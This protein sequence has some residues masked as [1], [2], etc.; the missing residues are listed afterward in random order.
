M[1]PA[2]PYR[3]NKALEKKGLAVQ[4]FRDPSGYYY[5][6]NEGPEDI[7]SIYSNNLSH[8]SIPEVIEYV[9]GHIKVY[10]TTVPVLSTLAVPKAKAIKQKKI[11]R[12]FD[13]GKSWT[14]MGSLGTA[15]VKGTL[16]WGA[17]KG[18]TFFCDTFPSGTKSYTAY[19]R[20][21]WCSPKQ[22]ADRR[23]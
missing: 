9:Y 20:M 6:I 7:P 22:V 3:V 4:M 19:Q 14:L 2:N 21:D 11:K 13:T 23:G 10:P 17:Q 15:F 16:V 18:D 5:F 1:T 12:V 8:M